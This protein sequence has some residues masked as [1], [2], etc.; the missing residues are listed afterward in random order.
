MNRPDALTAFSLVL[1]P[2]RTKNGQ[3]SGSFYQLSLI[4]SVD[5]NVLSSAFNFNSQAELLVVNLSEFGYV[6]A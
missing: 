1:K 4:F 6:L 3:T 5:S 2:L